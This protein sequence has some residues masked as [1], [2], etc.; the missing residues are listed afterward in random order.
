MRKKM[1]LRSLLVFVA[2]IY[3][4]CAGK[5]HAA[6]PK[7]TW[8]IEPKYEHGYRFSEGLW[9][10]KKDGLAGY[11][12]SADNVV[13][14]FKYLAG[15]PF[16][17]GMAFVSSSKDESRKL[18]KEILGIINKNGEYIIEP[19]PGLKPYVFKMDEGTVLFPFRSMEGKYGFL[20]LSRDVKISAVYDDV[21]TYLGMR[22]PS[23]GTILSVKSGDFWGMIDA[24]GQ[25]LI[26]PS[27]KN[28][29][30]PWN[31]Y[32]P[33]FKDGLWGLMNIKEE[34]ILEPRRQI[35]AR[36]RD[37]NS[38]LRVMVAD[39]RKIGFLDETLEYLIE[40]TFNARDG[41]SANGIYRG[42]IAFVEASSMYVALDE[43]GNVAFQIPQ[44]S[45]SPMP[46]GGNNVKG[47]Y[48]MAE[49]DKSGKEYFLVNKRGER[50]LPADFDYIIPSEEGIIA[51]KQ[52][53][54]WGLIDL[55]Q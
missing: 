36:E 21:W 27:Y 7:Y 46:H 52:N 43:K 39:D 9:G 26:P 4:C 19:Y 44:S 53:D 28:A 51:V 18:D 33:F 34:I 47:Y 29:L 14:D 25:W 24:Q 50:V 41:G 5:T 3:L 42:G 13:I 55:R 20:D 35:F 48:V 40:P 30:I 31:G 37:G 11:V 38:P 45:A 23:G 10:V 16:Q 22:I 17:G 1:F 32:I 8:L 6:E 12:D 2:S 49:N 15:R 54:L